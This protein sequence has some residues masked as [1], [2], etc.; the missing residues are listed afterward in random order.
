MV[1]HTQGPTERIE[2]VKISVD[3]KENFMNWQLV[4]QKHQKQ[5]PVLL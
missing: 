1:T 4:S 5:K 2:I 3:L